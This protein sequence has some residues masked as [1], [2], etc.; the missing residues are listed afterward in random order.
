MYGKEKDF[1]K[2]KLFETSLTRKGL[3]KRKLTNIYE[4]ESKKDLMYLEEEEEDEL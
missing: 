3:K 2:E 1:K 4:R